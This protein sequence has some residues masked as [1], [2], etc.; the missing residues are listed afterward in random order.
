MEIPE[1]SNRK[2]IDSDLDNKR[3]NN[4]Y[5]IQGYILLFNDIVRYDQVKWAKDGPVL[6]HALRSFMKCEAK[7]SQE[8]SPKLTGMIFCSVD[9]R[10]R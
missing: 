3:C 5:Q 1:G 10:N 9:V 7:Y 6:V 8:H 4:R 2:N